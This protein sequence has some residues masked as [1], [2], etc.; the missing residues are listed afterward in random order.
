M[1]WILLFMFMLSGLFPTYARADRTMIEATSKVEII[2]A[3]WYGPGFEGRPMANGKLFRS[4]DKTTA[5]HKTLPFGTRLWVTNPNNGRSLI[6][7][8]KDRGPYVKGRGLDLS[9]AAAHELGYAE[10]GV[11]ALEVVVMK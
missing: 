3:S 11:T 1:N 7:T 2:V 4:S 9:W 10:K 5:A 6:V 8:V